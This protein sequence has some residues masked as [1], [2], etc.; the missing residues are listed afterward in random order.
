MDATLAT[1]LAQLHAKAGVAGRRD[2]TVYGRARAAPRAF[3]THH[4]RAISLAITTAVGEA[5][6]EHAGLLKSE[7]HHRQQGDDA[8]ATAAVGA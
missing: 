8:T 4:T 5:L 7:I 1:R 6:L 2:G 3:I